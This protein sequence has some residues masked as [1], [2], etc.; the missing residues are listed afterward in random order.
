MSSFNEQGYQ[1][2][3][4]AISKETAKLLSLE[5]NMH[6][7]NVYLANNISLDVIGFNNHYSTASNVSVEK[8][9]SWAGFYGFE[10]L[11]KMMLWKVE[12]IV[13]KTLYPTYS[14][15]RIYYTGA[16]MAPHIDR[17]SCEYS[18]TMTLEVEEG[19]EPWEIWIR[20]LKG[21]ASAITIP[22]GSMVV[23]RGDRLEHWR[24]TY[25]G[26]KQIQVF[27]HYVDANGKY[28]DHKFDGRE[29]L[30]RPFTR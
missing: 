11:L 5:F 10:S 14:Y 19:K 12:N 2:V 15:S 13:G 26:N 18:A 30:G 16:T 25:T 4:N 24:D 17:P 23:Y 8:S 1:M 21:E 22:V 29:M 9:F 28:A 3:D 27:L 6:R 7:D 20:N